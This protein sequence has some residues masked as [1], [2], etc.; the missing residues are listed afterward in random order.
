[1]SEYY[2]VQRSEEYLAHYGVRG[3][4]WGVRKAVERGNGQGHSAAFNKAQAKLRRATTIGGVIG[5]AAGGLAKG[6]V[7]GAVGGVAGGLASGLGYLATHRKQL[8][9]SATTKAQYNK[10]K[11]QKANGSVNKKTAQLSAKDRDFVRGMNKATKK[12]GLAFGAVGGAVSAA[13]YM[14]QHPKEYAA[15]KKKYKNMSFKDRMR[16]SYGRV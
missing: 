9:N 12:P 3:M 11:Q 6:F 1:M 15:Y 13:K 7:G 2:A 10:M 16:A 4:K 14:K 5:G 8:K